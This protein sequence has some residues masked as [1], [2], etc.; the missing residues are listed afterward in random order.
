MFLSQEHGDLSLDVLENL[1]GLSL[2]ELSPSN[3]LVDLNKII[4]ELFIRKHYCVTQVV[5]YKK[6]TGK[7]K[8]RKISKIKNIRYYTNINC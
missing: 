6:E 1:Q 3:S 2:I 5:T 4:F 8:S 7:E